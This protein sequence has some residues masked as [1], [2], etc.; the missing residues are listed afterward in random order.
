MIKDYGDNMSN[1]QERLQKVIAQSGITSRRKA[2]QLIVDGRVKVNHQV[3]TT[4]GTKVSPND[5][6]AVD[7]VPIDKEENVYYLLYKPREYISSVSDD[8]GR[9]TVIGLMKGVSERIF[10]IG[11]LDYQTSGILLL[12]NDGEFAHILMHPK[13]E[14][15]KVYIV[16]IKGTPNK[17]KLQ[18]LL[19]GVTDD[20]ELLKAV[21]AKLKSIDRRTQTAIV[22]VTLHEGKN[23]H[24][25]RMMEQIGYPVLKIKRE[26]Y[27]PMTLQGLQPGQ[28][29]PLTRQ[30]IHQLK[31]LSNKNVK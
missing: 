14:L 26:K 29:R 24:I 10:P 8:K 17:D 20:G 9:D 27:G 12:T 1:A 23:R 13:Y 3:V 15:E 7:N 25:R 6:I 18:Q 2:E 4:L 5:E 16:K 28:F 22:E 11:R 19:K 31:S 30:E 21:K